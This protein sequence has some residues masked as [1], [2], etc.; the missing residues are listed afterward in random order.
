MQFIWIWRQTCRKIPDI[1]IKRYRPNWKSILFMT[2]IGKNQ[3]IEK[4]FVLWHFFSREIAVSTKSV[5]FYFDRF[6]SKLD[7]TLWNWNVEQIKP[8]IRRKN[9]QIW[10]HIFLVRFQCVKRFNL[11]DFFA[12]NRGQKSCQSRRCKL[13]IFQVFVKLRI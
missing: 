2:V 6:I 8:S 10:I 9:R 5:L 12:F 4:C 11:T 1:F 3:T 13:D 7:F